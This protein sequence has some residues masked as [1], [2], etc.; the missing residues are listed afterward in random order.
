MFSPIPNPTNEN[1][2]NLSTLTLG[3]EPQ[4]TEDVAAIFNI[5]YDNVA[6]GHNSNFNLGDYVD[7]PNISI[8]T[9]GFSG[10]TIG[11]NDILTSSMLHNSI[12]ATR[13]YIVSKNYKN[14]NSIAFNSTHLLTQRRYNTTNTNAGGYP[15]S[16]M[17]LFIENQMTAAILGAG[18]PESV[19]KV[20]PRTVSTM[21][22]T[23]ILNEKVFIPSTFEMFGV[24]ADNSTIWGDPVET[25]SNQGRFEYY[26]SNQRRTKLRLDTGAARHYWLSSPRSSYA[27]TFAV[28]LTTGTSYNSIASSANGVSPAF[29]VGA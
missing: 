21:G 18:V 13:F 27:N 20:V 17:K 2:R 9:D 29:C 16:E 23:S 12:P 15:A 22:G 19:I 10:W 25:A 8:L 11:Q 3:R 26:D 24:V 4:N 6:A 14:S 1:P 5:I 28:V 7:L